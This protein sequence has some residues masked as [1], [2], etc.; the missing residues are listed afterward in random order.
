[1]NK[2]L[3][4][5]DE[6]EISLTVPYYSC[7]KDYVTFIDEKGNAISIKYSVERPQIRYGKAWSFFSWNETECSEAF[8]LRQLNKAILF[9]HPNFQ[10]TEEKIAEMKKELDDKTNYIIDL[11]EE[12]QDFKKDNSQILARNVILTRQRNINRYIAI[13]LGCALII[14]TIVGICVFIG[15]SKF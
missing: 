8:Y 1:M 3:F 6:Q 14:Q 13:T 9:T 2:L 15:A 5:Q 11:A 12:N 10:T 4:R 7:D